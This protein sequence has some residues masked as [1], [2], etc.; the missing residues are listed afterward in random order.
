MLCDEKPV[1]K[2][3]LPLAVD[4]TNLFTKN[5]NEHYTYTVYLFA[6]LTRII[7][8]VTLSLTVFLDHDVFVLL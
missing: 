5:L 3:E 4:P 8:H 2:I 7:S 6:V 1:T